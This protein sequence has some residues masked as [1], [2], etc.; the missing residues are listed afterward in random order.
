MR[1]RREVL[2]G[3]YSEGHSG[4]AYKCSWCD[5]AFVDSY[6]EETVSMQIE[7]Y[8]RIITPVECRIKPS[9]GG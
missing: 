7:T 5:G 2:S 4:G 9:K 3:K 1:R 6:G 8:W